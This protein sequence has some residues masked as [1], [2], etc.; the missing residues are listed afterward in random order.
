VIKSVEKQELIIKTFQQLSLEKQCDR[1]RCRV[2]YSNAPYLMFV[3]PVI[4]CALRCANTRY[5]G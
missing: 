4:F 1:H 2:R 5:I 3:K